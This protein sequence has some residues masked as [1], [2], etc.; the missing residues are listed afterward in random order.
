AP[1]VAAVPALAACAAVPCPSVVPPPPAFCGGGPPSVPD[2][3]EAPAAPPWVPVVVCCA[4]A[5]PAVTKASAT[6][7]R[8][9]LRMSVLPDQ[10]RGRWPRL[11]NGGRIA[12]V[13]QGGG[14]GRG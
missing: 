2:T 3:A 7:V 14:C 13:P 5:T 12:S 8:S 9:A 11:T 10:G 1:P 6:P 4:Q